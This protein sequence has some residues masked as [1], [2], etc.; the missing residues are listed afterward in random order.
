MKSHYDNKPLTTEH[1]N[2]GTV[3]LRAN[4]SEEENGWSCIEHRF[5]GEPTITAR[6][7]RMQ[8]VLSGVNLEMISAGIDQLP[9]PD[10]SLARVQWE[11]ATVF[12]RNNHSMIEMAEQLGFTDEQ[13]N[14]IFIEGVAL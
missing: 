8:L 12:E 9:E 11:Y 2:D 14:Q 3:I 7:L 13:L 6:Q 4:I 1:D 5:T 10:Q